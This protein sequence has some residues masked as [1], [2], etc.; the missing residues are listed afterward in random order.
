MKGDDRGST[1]SDRD[2]EDS[3]REREFKVSCAD[4]IRR[5]KVH[6]AHFINKQKA[7][8]PHCSPENQS[9]A[10]KL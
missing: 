3:H 9:L 7:H 5:G 1:G 10:I 8:G 6:L 4:V 2:D